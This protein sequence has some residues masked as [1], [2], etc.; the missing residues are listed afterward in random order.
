MRIVD[1]WIYTLLYIYM[2]HVNVWNWTET[3]LPVLCHRICL[4]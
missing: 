2:R 1:L 4:D 3:Y